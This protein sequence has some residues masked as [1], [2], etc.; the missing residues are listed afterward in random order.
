M[1]RT[2]EREQFVADNARMARI[3]SKHVKPEHIEP[4][5]DHLAAS[6]D[7]AAKAGRLDPDVDLSDDEVDAH[8]RNV[9]RDNPHIARPNPPI[10]RTW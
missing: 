7:R 6:Y 4:T 2:P 5:L 10:K 1:S 8:V 3:A 9:V